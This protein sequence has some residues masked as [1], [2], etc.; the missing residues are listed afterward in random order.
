MTTLDPM[1]NGTP[2]TSA[3]ELL[4]PPPWD[5][6]REAAIR[7]LGKALEQHWPGAEP[8]TLLRVAIRFVDA[9][10]PIGTTQ[11]VMLCPGSP[12]DVTRLAV[13]VLASDPTFSGDP[14]PTDL[15]A[16]RQVLDRLLG[17]PGVNL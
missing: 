12:E 17:R 10:L 4:P 7:S 11:W 6:A 9:I 1:T 5:Q 2:T 8:A 16:S 14:S 13:A 15:V 3:P